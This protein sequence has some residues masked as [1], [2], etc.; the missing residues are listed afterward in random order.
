MTIT[1]IMELEANE[2]TD[3]LVGVA[4]GWH[5]YSWR[6]MISSGALE[7]ER[8]WTEWKRFLAPPDWEPPDFPPASFFPEYKQA[9]AGEPLAAA[10]NWHIA[11]LPKY[12]RSDALAV[13]LL[14][15]VGRVSVVFLGED[16]RIQHVDGFH[17]RG[18]L[19]LVAVQCFLWHHHAKQGVAP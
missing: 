18:I 1:E 11:P 12:S 10:W 17:A 3:A 4:L 5:W 15:R 2:E 9:E 7:R 8:A 14:S 6:H 19:P 16:V 13:S